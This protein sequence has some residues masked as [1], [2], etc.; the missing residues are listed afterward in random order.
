MVY[1]LSECR[2]EG[3]VG[4]V[5]VTSGRLGGVVFALAIPV[6]LKNGVRGLV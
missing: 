3:L 4:S 5:L 1:V 2:G 6:I